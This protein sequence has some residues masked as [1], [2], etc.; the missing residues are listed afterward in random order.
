MH[1][2]ILY[3]LLFLA[4]VP[5]LTMAG[6]KGRIK[7]TVVDLQT[8]EPLIGANVIVVGSSIGAATDANGEFVLLNLEAGVFDLK[9]SYLGYQTITLTGV[10]V[11]ADLTTYVTFELPDEEVQ[12]GTVEIIASRPLIQKDA[13]NATR[14]TTSEDID[15]LPVRGVNNIVALTAGVVLK[16]N[17]VF[18]RGGRIDE[19]GFYLEGVSIKDPLFGGRAITLSQDALEEIQVQAGGYTAEF[20]GANAGIIRQQ[21]KSGGPQFRAS[22]FYETDNIGFK[23]K[24]DAFDGEKTLGAYTYGY[25]EMSGV[26][27]GPLFDQRV[28]F[29]GNVHY[30]YRRDRQPQPWPGLDLGPIGDPFTHDTVDFTYAAGPVK[31]YSLE[32]MTYAGTINLDFKPILIRLSGTYTADSRQTG[33]RGI[34]PGFVISN[35]ENTRY[36]YT[37]TES[38]SFSLKL[39][40]V[41]SPT[42]FYELSAGYFTN[43]DERGDPYLKENFWAYGDS[44][45]NADAGWVW[46]RSENDIANN[47]TGRYIRPSQKSVYGFQFTRNG[48]NPRNFLKRDQNSISLS[49]ALSFFV[50]KIHSFKLGG[51][52]QQY[53]MRQWTTSSS[54]VGMA[55][56]LNNEPVQDDATK[57]KLLRQAG[58]NNYGYD[59]LG[60]VLDDDE[61][62]GPKKPVFASAYIQ[63]RIEFE[64]IILNL[65]LRYDYIDVDHKEFLDPT[66][67]DAAIPNATTIVKEQFVDIASFSSLSPRLGFSFPVTDNTVFHAQYGKFVQQS[68]LTDIYSGWYRWSYELTN[69]FFFGSPF[70]QNLR[71]TRTTQYELGFTQQV[72]D[73]ISVDITGYYRDI[74]DQVV[75][76][77]LAV[78]RNSVYQD[79]LTLRNGDF[80]TTKGLEITFNMRRTNRLAL[81][82]TLSFQD[83]QGTG[84]F[85]NSNRGIVG[86]PLDGVTVFTP[87]YISPLE[88]NQAL[89]G[90][91]NLDYRFGAN[92]GPA[93]LH[94]LGLSVLAKFGSGHP[95]TRGIGAADLEGDARNRRPIEPLNASTTPSTLQ[96]DLRIDKSF[97][98]MDELSLNVYFR[99]ENLLDAAN[100]QNVFLRTGSAVDDGYISNPEYSATLLETYGQTYAD[101][102]KAVNLDYY[103]QYLQAGNLNTVPFMYGPPRSYRLGIRLEY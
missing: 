55:Q 99:V 64:D 71:P 34:N 87:Q 19:V 35:I 42:M 2:K 101:I 11:N 75:F 26:I 62:F 82:A 93:A 30:N 60:N 16:D 96:V 66:K 31:G 48:D 98:I 20:G 85:P 10:R 21:L 37:D 40:H 81:N 79:Y 5:A 23:S 18:V 74:K 3:F 9:S 67:P 4:L 77:S 97:Q 65:G 68:R 27:S 17:V 36:G 25:N 69:S 41:L 72:G 78:D 54:Q 1:R 24:D 100:Y 33:G 29:F 92:D 39:T 73:N 57:I 22:I 53:T 83:A 86:A 103:E 58:V 63:D 8:G 43:Y 90:N 46:E 15:A 91:V 76:N 56:L 32:S 45:A 70:G 28:K 50:G 49:G 47:R 80:A 102:Y 14:I 59:E 44:V 52:Y 88:F 51:E 84:S 38:G 95:F 7:G 89:S 94:E 12:V 6:T 61:F 13:T